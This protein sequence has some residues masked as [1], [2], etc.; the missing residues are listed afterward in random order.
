VSRV[1]HSFVAPS[2]LSLAVHDWGGTGDS[3]LLAHPTGFHGVAWQPVAERLVAHGRRVW[4]FDFRGHGDSDPSPDGTYSWDGFADDARAVLDHLD[5]RDDPRLV[6]VGH[7]KGATSLMTVGWRTPGTVARIWAFEPIV[8]P[9]Y[10]ASLQDPDNPMS[11]SARRRRAVWA[12]RDE[13]I[14]SYG[15]KYP[16][17]VLTDEAL[18]AYV[19]YGMRDRPDGTVELKCGP[20]HEATIYTMGVVNG[21]WDRLPELACPVLVAAGETSTAIPPSLAARITERLPHGRLE[22]WPG[23]GHFGPME[24]PDRAVASIL[25]FAGRPPV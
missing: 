4:S 1:Q 22:L 6:A 23:H 25:D 2:G 19:D 18:H 7:S 20:E 21:L 16:L 17:D 24:D 9:R 8:F 15:S 5:L 3:V 13:A 14:A 12:S 10:D 11:A